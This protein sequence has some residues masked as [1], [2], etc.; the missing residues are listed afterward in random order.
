[1]SA[2][3]PTARWLLDLRLQAGV[4]HPIPGSARTLHLAR[5]IRIPRNV[6]CQASERKLGRFSRESDRR[7][8][9]G[10]SVAQFIQ[11]LASRNTYLRKFGLYLALEQRSQH[12][13]KAGL[14]PA[15]EQISYL[16]K[17]I[18]ATEQLTSA[19]ATVTQTKLALLG[20]CAKDHQEA[21]GTYLNGLVAETATP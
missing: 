11:A 19:R 4:P 5:W 1:M 14:A 8:K 3:L 12:R 20:Q 7:T 15:T 10:Q 13:V 9:V 21:V 2:R 6:H 16:E 17:V 18:E